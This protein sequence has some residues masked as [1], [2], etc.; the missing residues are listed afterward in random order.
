MISPDRIMNDKI[1]FDKINDEIKDLIKEGLEYRAD[2]AYVV[3][4][5]LINYLAYTLENPNDKQI[6]R[7]G[8]LIKSN[9]LGMDLKF[10]LAKKITNQSNKYN[11]LLIDTDIVDLILE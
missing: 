7:L 9:C 2:L 6:E 11:A 4:T 3:T 5:R 8:D 10:V 1:P